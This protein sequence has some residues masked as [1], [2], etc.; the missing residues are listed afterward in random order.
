MGETT[1]SRQYVPKGQGIGCSK[2]ISDGDGR[3][4]SPSPPKRKSSRADP[5]LSTRLI[6]SRILSSSSCTTGRA[7]KSLNSTATLRSEKEFRLLILLMATVGSVA[8]VAAADGRR[9]AA[10]T[11]SNVETQARDMSSSRSTTI[12]HIIIHR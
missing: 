4:A 6:A 8:A 1:P 7:T 11:T 2:E 9:R 5:N 3:S 10:T 12:S